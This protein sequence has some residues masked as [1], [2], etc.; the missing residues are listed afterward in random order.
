MGVLVIS[1]GIPV[2]WVFVCWKNKPR[3]FQLRVGMSP[4]LPQTGCVF[5]F[6]LIFDVLLVL[7]LITTCNLVYF[8]VI[9][10]MTAFVQKLLL[11]LPE[12]S[13]DSRKA[14]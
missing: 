7:H 10:Q 5:E 3:S 4:I 11:C 6:F 12:D 13:S 14:N 9:E 8:S 2:Y 1:S